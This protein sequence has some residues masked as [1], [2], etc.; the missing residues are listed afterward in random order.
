MENTFVKSYMKGLDNSSDESRLRQFYG[1][2]DNFKSVTLFFMVIGLL[3]ALYIAY[4]GPRLNDF[5]LLFVRFMTFM[6][7]VG[8]IISLLLYV[9]TG[10]N[11]A[12]NQRKVVLNILGVETSHLEKILQDIIMVVSTVLILIIAIKGNNADKM[13]FHLYGVT[14]MVQFVNAL[15]LLYYSKSA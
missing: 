10:R 8:T 3:F 11:I 1:G 15:Y 4:T 6:M 13:V 12:N 2:N 14:A 5:V 7:I 9:K